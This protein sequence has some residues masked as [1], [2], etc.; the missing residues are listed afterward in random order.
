MQRIIRRL[1]AIIYWSIVLIPFSIA[2]GPAIANI[3]IGFMMGSFL[4][5]KLLRREKLFISTPLNIPYI[6][7]ILA[8]LVSLKNSLNYA[9]SLHGVEK[10]IRNASVF[11]ICAEKIK[12]RSHVNKIIFSIICGAFLVSID[13]FWQIAFGRDF[14]RGNPM[15]TCPIDLARVTASFPNP[16]VMAV[17]LTAIAALII[18]LT[19]FHYKGKIKA[20]MSVISISVATGIFLTFSR[21]AG[22]GLYLSIF[23]L[24]VARKKKILSF[25][26]I[27][28]LL[29][30]PFV[31]PSNIK[32]WARE[33]K[34]QPLVF[35]C[36]YD[37]ISIYR[38]AL[39][40]IKHHPFIGVGVNTFSKNYAKY[41]LPEPENAKTPDSIYAHNIYLHT[42]GEIGLLGLGAFLWMLFSLFKKNIQIY[43]NLKDDYLQI[44]SI[45][46]VA[47]LIAFLINGFTETNLYYA[48]VAMIFWYI[49]GFSLALNKFTGAD[50]P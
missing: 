48:R 17:Y 11:L 27:G 49:I 15:D 44:I 6:F 37:R 43:N 40:M 29:I 35:L 12:D 50:K 26:L 46:L 25:I 7:L 45:S 32:N 13:A 36:N 14:I 34:Y 18:G 22:L 31:M 38:N 16:N 20:I 24:S 42:A 28:I 3:L 21:G 1:E 19:I 30:F 47:C 8:A 23:F 5:N 9:D 10:L 2:I 41:K 33:I 39:N 4:L